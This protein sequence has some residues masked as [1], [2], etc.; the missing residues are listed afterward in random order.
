[1]ANRSSELRLYALEDMSVAANM[2]RFQASNADFS[3]EGPQAMKFDFGSVQ[4]TD[5]YGGTLYNVTSR[6]GSIEGDVTGNNTTQTAAT[7]AVAADLAAEGVARAAQDVV[8]G[9]QISS[10]IAARATAVTAVADALDVQEL[11]QLNEDA[12]QTAARATEISNRTAGDAAEAAARTAADNALQLQITT[13]LGANTPAALQNLTA[14]VNAFQ[15]QDVTHTSAIA[16]L[17]TKIAAIEATL[18][19]L[20]NSGL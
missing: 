12:A 15:G 9:N 2:V 1:M 6:F 14:I 3:A 11:K 10:E 16:S 19:E 7:A 17:V 4:I 13:L 8:L 20:V 18:N 5:S